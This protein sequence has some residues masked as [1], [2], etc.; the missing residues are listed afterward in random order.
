[1]SDQ[2]DARLVTVCDACLRACCW[3]G[4]FMCDDSYGAGTTRKTVAELRALDEEHSDY[5]A[6]DDNYPEPS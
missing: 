4:I 5:Y 3:R 2:E 6:V 1:M